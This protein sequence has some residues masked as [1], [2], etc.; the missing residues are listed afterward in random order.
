MTKP[1]IAAFALFT[2][3]FTSIANSKEQHSQHGR[4]PTRD[5]ADF[6]AHHSGDW[7]EPE[8][9]RGKQVPSMSA[10]V[11]IPD[12]IT[13]SIN[14][15]VPEPVN[16]IV[17]DGVLFFPGT[18][19]AK[20]AVRTIHVG[21]QGALLIGTKSSPVNKERVVDIEF[22]GL[23]S[24]PLG[25]GDVSGGLVSMGRVEFYGSNKTP[26]A[27]SR[28]ALTA[29]KKELYFESL[30]GWQVGDQ[31]L[32]PATELN[33]E[34]ELRIIHAIDP[35][36]GLVKLDIALN[37][38]HLLPKI[39][40][41]LVPVANLSR[42]IRLSTRA[43]VP[44]SRRAHTMF[45]NRQSGIVINGAS[46][47]RIGRTSANDTHTV[48]TD[49]KLPSNLINTIGRYAIHF[50]I[51]KGADRKKDPHIVS[52]SVI[53]ECA[54]HG[55]VNHGG[56]V[57]ATYNVTFNCNGSHFFAEN[58]SEV[59]SFTHNLAVR[60]NGSGEEFIS[61][62]ANADFGHGGH[63]FWMQGG[64]GVEVRGN[65]AFGHSDAAYFYFGQ[66]MMEDGEVAYFDA[67]NV[68]NSEVAENGLRILPR[69]IPISFSSNVAVSSLR[70]LDIWNHKERADH[71][72]KSYVRD[73]VFY[74]NKLTAIFIP[75]S[76][77]IVLQN[78]IAIGTDD[79]HGIG[80]NTNVKTSGL[81]IENSVIEGYAV[82]LE[83]PR[84]GVTQVNGLTLKNAINV[85]GSSPL[86]QNRIVEFEN[87]NLVSMPNWK[88]LLSMDFDNALAELR[89]LKRPQYDFYLEGVKPT[90]RG[91]LSMILE[92]SPIYVKS[93]KN[94]YV[95]K[96]LY[97]PEQNADVVP[98]EN[99][100]VEE[101]KG[102]TNNYGIS[103]E[104]LWVA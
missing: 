25:H 68:L 12:G 29:G 45:M 55:V 22:I 54:K 98:F 6:I 89:Y 61:R 78:V 49:A 63:G 59:G 37:E 87:L 88:N 84:H 11:S 28:S 7:L 16:T 13:V 44:V 60:S 92:P 31:L 74:A 46:F 53:T 103:S 18:R 48:P 19:N 47:S 85:R 67:D 82:G 100:E 10:S 42:N 26:Y 91:D 76:K 9:W 56:H 36:D 1:L 43:D 81:S 2:L 90:E 80:L 72:V 52:N 38:D 8:T 4:Q 17:I 65:F 102:L 104:W 57:E 71:T 51:R 34:D 20:L 5:H 40:N 93:G 62:E 101:L 64:G 23:E 50:H 35:Q 32:F 21:A 77:N 24:D 73:S 14:S 86:S 30:D 97:F 94:P 96:Q 95:A 66:Y 83:L 75:Y 3:I 33:Q 58:G 27:I 69:D 41:T 15:I 39:S 99:S 79:F 70:G